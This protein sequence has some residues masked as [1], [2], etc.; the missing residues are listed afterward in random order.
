MAYHNVDVEYENGDIRSF[1]VKDVNH[2]DGGT[3][4]LIFPDGTTKFIQRC[5]EVSISPL[6]DERTDEPVDFIREV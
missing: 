5:V 4:E 1:Q 2:F 6:M 3:I